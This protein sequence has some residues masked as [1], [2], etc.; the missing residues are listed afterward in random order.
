M[1]LIACWRKMLGIDYWLKY[2]CKT[3]LSAAASIIK[4]NKWSAG[5]WCECRWGKLQFESRLW[6]F[7]LPR[8][9]SREWWIIKPALWVQEQE[10]IFYFFFLKTTTFKLKYFRMVGMKYKNLV[11]LKTIHNIKLV[12]LYLKK[13]TFT[14][15]SMRQ[16]FFNLS[17]FFSLKMKI[18]LFGSI[19]YLFS[20][21]IFLFPGESPVNKIFWHCWGKKLLACGIMLHTKGWIFD[22]RPIACVHKRP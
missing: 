5:T 4:H 19:C 13:K 16:G 8:S 22:E 9:A 2:A 10:Q 21:L 18:S 20:Q 1:L 7:N 6:N 15:H 3:T 11:S 12:R 14:W 17:F